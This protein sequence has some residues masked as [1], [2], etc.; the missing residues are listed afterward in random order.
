MVEQCRLLSSVEYPSG[1]L[2]EVRL[3]SFVRG[4][5][6]ANHRETTAKSAV[7]DGCFLVDW[8]DCKSTE[9]GRRCGERTQP[10]L[11]TTAVQGVGVFL[12]WCSSQIPVI[13]R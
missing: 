4:Y 2:G 8:V 7:R 6:W 12:S 1:Q 9:R 11:P 10:D 5:P 3:E 13:S